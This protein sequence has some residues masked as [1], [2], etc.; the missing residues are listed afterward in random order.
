MGRRK[1]WEVNPDTIIED[2]LRASSD[3]RTR[4][5]PRTLAEIDSIKAGRKRGKAQRMARRLAEKL[6]AQPKAPFVIDRFIR[7]MEP[8]EWYGLNSVADAAGVNVQHQGIVGRTLLQNRLAVRQGNPAWTVRVM[9][10]GPIPPGF[11]SEPKWLYRLTLAG[12]ARRLA[13]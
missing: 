5:D 7:L 11:R 2:L 3:K 12:E 10:R 9:T 1:A 8:G 6:A 4:T 13:L